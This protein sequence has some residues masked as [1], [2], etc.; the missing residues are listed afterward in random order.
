MLTPKHVENLHFF[1]FFRW[2][3]SLFF[4]FIALDFVDFAFFYKLVVSLTSTPKRENLFFSWSLDSCLVTCFICFRLCCLSIFSRYFE[5]WCFVENFR[6]NIV[7]LYFYCV[8][9]K[10][11]INMKLLKNLNKYVC[12]FSNKMTLMDLT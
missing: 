12:A 3:S 9:S 5:V 2:K 4:S 11:N 8:N 7:N 1:S 10:I 6:I